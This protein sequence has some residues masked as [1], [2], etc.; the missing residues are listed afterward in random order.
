MLWH[1]VLSGSKST[2]QRVELGVSPFP[3]NHTFVDPVGSACANNYLDDVVP[4]EWHHHRSSGMRIPIAKLEKSEEGTI[5]MSTGVSVTSPEMN[6]QNTTRSAH[7]KSDA[8]KEGCHACGMRTLRP[9]AG[10]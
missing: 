3:A 2:V 7:R 8:M 6:P 5:A 9:T 10:H 1:I 4:E